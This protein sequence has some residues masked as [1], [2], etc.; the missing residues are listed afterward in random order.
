MLFGPKRWEKFQGFMKT[1]VAGVVL[2]V[3]AC[4]VL[5]EHTEVR[6]LRGGGVIDFEHA[7]LVAKVTAN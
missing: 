6:Y 7:L 5:S 1:V 3:S 4:T 2:F